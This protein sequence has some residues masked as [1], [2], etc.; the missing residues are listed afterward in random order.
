MLQLVVLCYFNCIRYDWCFYFFSAIYAILWSGGFASCLK[1][2]FNDVRDCDVIRNVLIHNVN[3]N[4]VRQFILYR[5]QEE[6]NSIRM[7]YYELY[8]IDLIQDINE[9]LG[10]EIA[11]R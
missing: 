2:K 7:K 11:M 5:N 3:F 1:S 4:V 6:R 10:N 8:N 9:H